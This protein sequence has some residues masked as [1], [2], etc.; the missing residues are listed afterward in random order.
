MSAIETGHLLVLEHSVSELKTQLT[1]IK[2]M[3]TAQAATPTRRRSLTIEGVMHETGLESE[4]A[5]RRWLKANQVR[6]YAPGKWFL[7]AVLSAMSRRSFAEVRAT[8][9]A[10]AKVAVPATGGAL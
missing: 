5:A 1:E 9:R 10:A 6:P 7:D 3:L 2:A 4:S 8:R